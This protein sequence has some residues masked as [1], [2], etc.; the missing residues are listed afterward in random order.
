MFEFSAGDAAHAKPR[1]QLMA[2][3]A[4]S[5]PTG[6]QW[7]TSNDIAYKCGIL[8]HFGYKNKKYGHKSLCQLRVKYERGRRSRTET[9]MIHESDERCEYGTMEQRVRGEQKSVGRAQPACVC[10]RSRV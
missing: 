6:L 5:Q 10:D 1:G 7:I 9:M 3:R 4:S 8:V 2:F